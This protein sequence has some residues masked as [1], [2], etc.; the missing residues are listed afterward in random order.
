VI[1]AAGFPAAAEHIVL[2]RALVD[3][4]L[5]LTGAYRTGTKGVGDVFQFLA[6]DVVTKH[7]LGADRLFFDTLQ[8]QATATERP[9]KRLSSRSKPPQR[10]STPAILDPRA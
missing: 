5:K 1:V 8:P 10:Q 2:H 4:A 7:M 9:S 6:Y 3:Q